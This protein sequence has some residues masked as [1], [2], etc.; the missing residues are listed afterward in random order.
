MIDFGVAKAT[1]QKLTERTMFTEFG[2]VIGTVEYMSPEQAKFNQLDIDT[3]SDIYSLGVLLYELLTGSTPFE[4]K[5]LREAAFDEVL[6]IIR[7]E[8]PPK[9]S[10]RLST[11]PTRC[12]RSPPTGTR[13]P[14]RLSK[15]VRGELDWIVMKCLEKDR[16]R[17]YETANGLARDIERYLHDEPVQACPPSAA[18]RFRKFARRNKRTLRRPRCSACYSSAH[19]RPWP[20]ASAGRPVTEAARQAAVEREVSLALQEVQ[21]AYE[22]DALSDAM[23]AV[24]KAEAVLASGAPQP[25]LQRRVERWKTDLRLVDRSRKSDWT[26]AM[27]LSLSARS[28]PI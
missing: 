3:R 17:R 21:S 22:K 26:K 4:R 5:R 24:K 11:Q 12:R 20:A 18:Y 14:A 1:A 25:H 16:N 28:T 15:D 2:Q 27:N 10:T 13:E 6:R 19:L 9:P 8:E 7:E 23:A